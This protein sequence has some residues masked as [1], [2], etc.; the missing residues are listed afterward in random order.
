MPVDNRK[1]TKVN[2]EEVLNEPVTPVEPIIDIDTPVETPTEP[3]E[4]VETSIEKPAEVEKS[5]EESKPEVKKEEPDYKEKFSESSREAMSLHFKAEKLSSLLSEDLEVPEPT[6]GDLRAYAKANDADFDELD[7]FS[8]NILK[9]TLI[10][11]QKEAKRA[12]AFSEIKKLDTWANK[13]NDFVS[14]EENMT[15][16]SSLEGREEDF[17][18]YCMKETQRG[19]DFDLLVASYLYKNEEIPVAKKKGS[20]FLSRGNGRAETPPPVGVSAGEAEV[21]RTRDPKE[22]R[23]LIKAG[24]IKIE[25]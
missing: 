22:Y 12:A 3:V 8:K 9:R 21:I 23:R 25:I 14:S 19:V 13:V 6:E 11:E 4:P 24:K 15:K 20:L 16:Y 7:S 2:V 10:S 1:R 5:V 17:K 18:R